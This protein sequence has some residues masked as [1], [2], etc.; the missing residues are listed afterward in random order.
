MKKIYNFKNATIIVLNANSVDSTNIKKSTEK[1][2]KKIIK[3]RII[4]GNGS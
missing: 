4:N 2:V 1:F 3:E